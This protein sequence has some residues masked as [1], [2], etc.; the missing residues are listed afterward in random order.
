MKLL[1]GC[2]VENENTTT[3]SGEMVVFYAHV[4]S[5]FCIF[6]CRALGYRREGACT[7]GINDN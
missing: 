4:K 2:Q 3:K 1:A 6:P 5:S 7:N